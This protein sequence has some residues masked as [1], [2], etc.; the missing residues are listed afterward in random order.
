MSKKVEVI[1]EIAVIPEMIIKSFTDPKM[2]RDWWGVERSLIEKRPGGIYTLTWNVSEKGFGYV[3]SGIISEY[4]F[5]HK[6]VIENLVY[7]NPEKSILGPMKLTVTAK[8]KKEGSELYIC[9]DGYREGGDW[10]WY[11]QAV[12][13]AWPVVTN[14]LKKYLEGS[15]YG[16]Y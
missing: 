13:K 2:L 14:E 15:E 3:T 12:K 10:E 8:K 16:D 6:I 11:F 5:D 7:L 9:Q 4:Q 1:I